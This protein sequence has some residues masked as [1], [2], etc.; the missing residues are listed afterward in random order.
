[1]PATQMNFWT[2][3]VIENIKK[4]TKIDLKWAPKIDPKSIKIYPGTLQGFP[5]CIFGQLD[6]PKWSPRT[7]KWTQMNLKWSSKDPKIL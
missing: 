2:V 7:P 1:M 4:S 6:H 5:E 3:Q